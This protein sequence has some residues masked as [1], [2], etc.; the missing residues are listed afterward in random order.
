MYNPCT[1]F[2]QIGWERWA[3]QTKTAR[4]RLIE[5]WGPLRYRLE[6][7]GGTEKEALHVLDRYSSFYGDMAAFSVGGENTAFFTVKTLVM[8]IIGRGCG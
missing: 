7:I 3:D 5:P 8:N 4:N 1:D 2:L 6:Q